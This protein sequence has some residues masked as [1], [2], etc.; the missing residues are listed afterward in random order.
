MAG[1]TGFSTGVVRN[2]VAFIPVD[3]LSEAGMNRV[4]MTDRTWLRLMSA[5]G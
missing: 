2:S 4:N 3:T 5:C 1:Y